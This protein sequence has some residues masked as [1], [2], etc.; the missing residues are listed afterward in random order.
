MVTYFE[1]VSFLSD[2]SGSCGC[3]VLFLEVVMGYVLWYCAHHMVNMDECAS[4]VQVVP[5]TL[6]ANSCIPVRIVVM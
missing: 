2:I 4:F 6:E 1:L 5:V 3:F